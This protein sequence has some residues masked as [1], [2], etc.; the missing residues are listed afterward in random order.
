MHSGIR[1]LL[2]L[3]KNVSNVRNSKVNFINVSVIR[4]PLTTKANRSLYMI[5]Q[6]QILTKK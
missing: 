4:M 6:L 1:K 2:P 3:Y 5:S